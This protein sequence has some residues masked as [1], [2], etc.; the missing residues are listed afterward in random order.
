MATSHKI[1]SFNN[2]N[3]RR[4][5]SRAP[6]STLAN[7]YTYLNTSQQNRNTTNSLPLCNLSLAQFRSYTTAVTELNT[8][9]VNCSKILSDFITDKKLS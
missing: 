1:S 4:V 8:R 3:V 2:K 9:N 7:K 6:C 5:V